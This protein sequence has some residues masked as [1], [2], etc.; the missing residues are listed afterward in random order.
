MRRILAVFFT[1][2]L[3][4]FAR[5]P[6]A[7][8]LEA[9]QLRENIIAGLQGGQ[10]PLAAVPFSFDEVRVRP[11]GPGFRVEITGLASIPDAGDPWADI[12]DLAFSVEETGE[13]LYRVDE[14]AGLEEVSL[15]DTG[16]TQVGLFA[17]RWDRFTGTWSRALAGFLEADLLLG[18]LRFAPADGS[19]L[20]SLDRL[21]SVNRALDAGGGRFDLDGQARATGLRAEMPGQG[22][23]EV[24][25]I[26]VESVTRGVDL[27]AFGA[28]T[29]EWEALSQGREPPGEAEVAAF[30]E[31]MAARESLLP[32]GFAQRFVLSNLSVSD[33]AGQHV[34]GIDQI[35]WDAAGSALNQ[36]LAETRLGAQHR[37]L[38][39]GEGVNGVGVWRDL[40]PSEAGFVVAAERLP[41]NKLWKALFKA[42][43]MAARQAPTVEP[44]SGFEDMALMLL[45]SELGPAFGEAGTRIRLPHLRIVSEALEAS[46]EG[47]AEVDPA[48]VNGLTGTLDVALV[49]LD[50]TLALV[51]SQA[52]PEDPNAQMALMALFW[53]KT[54]AQREADAEGRDVDRIAVQMSAD[55][56]ILLNGQPMG[57][58]MLPQ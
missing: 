40:V 31:R 34:F 54:V 25:E 8:A 39:L 50:Q 21:G 53:L 47:L 48:A 4:V 56:Q 38:V 12:G 30:L 52:S 13:G 36:P 5:P 19:A 2:A 55:G 37:G 29:R 41:G 16:G 28:L 24:R 20:L 23:F 58:P 32:S 57:M 51:Q 14:V 49:G 45:L 3:I 44:G 35:E 27:D 33:V 15:R 6:Q 11:D 18:N 9:D 43:A 46:A 1:T 42:M 26:A 22:V 10:G 7:V 17:A